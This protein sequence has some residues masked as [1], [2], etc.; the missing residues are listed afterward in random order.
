MQRTLLVIVS[1]FCFYIAPAQKKPLDHTVYDGWQHIGERLIS[2][3]GKWV[4]FT[5]DPQEGDNELVIRSSDTMYTKAIPRGYNAVI[6]EDSRYLVFKIKPTFKETREA[7]IRKKKADDMPKDSLAII[8][9]GKDDTWKR[10]MV[11]N[12]KTPQRSFGWVAYQLENLPAPAV[13]PKKTDSKAGSKMTDSLNRVIDSLQKLIESAPQKRKKNKN[14]DDD[15]ADDINEATGSEPYNFG[16]LTPAYAKASAGKPDSELLTPN[17]TGDAEGDEPP[18]APAEPAND[19]VLKELSTGKEM[20]FAKVLEYYFSKTGD[21]LL[22]EQATDPADSLST[23]R[24]VLYDLK[25]GR[26]VTLSKGGNE[27][28]NF[29][30]SEDGS[31]VAYVAERDAKQRDLVKF[32]KL[33]HYKEGMDTAEWIVD[34]NST[35]MKLGMTVSEHGNISFSKSGRRLFFGS[36]PV[37]VPRDTTLIE[38]DMPKLDIWHY[39]DDYLQT[40]QNF[41]ARLRAAQQENYL[42]MY[43]LETKKI[44]QIGSREIP[45]VLPTNEGDGETFVGVTD[46]GKRVESQWLGPTRKDI[47]AIDVN[48]G[49]KMMVKENLHGQVYPSATGKY[50]M[51]YDRKAREYFIWDGSGVKNITEKIR[52]AMWNEEFDSP[53]DPNNYGVMGW[54]EGDSTVYVYD[55]YDIWAVDLLDNMSPRNMTGNG[56]SAKTT[57]RYLPLNEDERYFTREQDAVFHFFN[58]ETKESGLVTGKIGKTIAP[59]HTMTGGK[60]QFGLYRKARNAGNYIYTKESFSQSPDIFLKTVSPTVFGESSVTGAPDTERQLS[61][62]NPQQAGYRWGSAELFKWKAYN[63]KEATGIVY[64]PEQFDPKKKYPVIVYFYEKLSQGLFDYKEPAPIRSAVNVPYFVSNGYI[65][66]MPDIEY[67]TGYPGQ[68]AYDY[69][70]SGAR[71]LVKKGWADSTN[72][73]LQGHSWGG[74][75]AAQ[76]ATMT[77]LFKAVW[78]G[79]PVANMTSAYGGIRWESGVNRQFQYEKAQS[80]IGAT[81]WERPDLY[82]KNSPLFQLDKVT[83]PMVILHNDADGAVPWYQGIE[84]FTGLRRLGKKVWMLNYN[85]QGHGLTQR[86]DMKDYHIRMQQFFDYMLKG[87][88]PTRWITEGVPAV[89]KGKEWGLEMD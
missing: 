74:Y 20:L 21:K 78:A 31:Q 1:V 43:D 61:S 10:P 42:T 15:E 57:Y 26:P 66:F 68:S 5:I 67:K 48:T 51:W 59:M 79:A 12:Y 24:V 46:F 85:G 71:A 39:N 7:K 50:I 22:F 65:I 45:Q 40:V 9:L 8:E 76:L 11:K 23:R 82:I 18:T 69:I 41:P 75:Q 28:K 89:K 14:K 6:T 34:K 70:V 38:M 4:V 35:G 56:R 3:D 52:P 32:Y 29:A 88:R 54:Y 49:Y 30:M 60:F 63:G 47:Y 19:L 36:A 62:I 33:W 53:D 83:A 44:R 58:Q 55:R 80:R 25:T 86:Q 77:K 81:L 84:L 87:A 13:R 16:V 17:L 2:N 64:K 73:A 27:F 37:P 72:M